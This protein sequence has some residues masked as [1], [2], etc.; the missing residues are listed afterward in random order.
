MLSPL[1]V[2]ELR[3]P[4]ISPPNSYLPPLRSLSF[5]LALSFALAR[6]LACSRLAC[7]L[8]C[9]HPFTQR[10]TLTP[11]RLLASTCEDAANIVSERSDCPPA[12]VCLASVACKLGLH[13]PAQRCELLANFRLLV[14]NLLALSRAVNNTQIHKLPQPPVSFGGRLLCVASLSPHASALLFE[15]AL[16]LVGCPGQQQTTAIPP[17]AESQ[18]SQTWSFLVSF[19]LGHA[20]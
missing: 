2:N 18:G 11:L 16:G 9:S 19:C 17:E 8:T 12:T 13:R 14:L 7:S 1:I 10:L 5:S 4:L 3:S 6:S 15:S 20:C